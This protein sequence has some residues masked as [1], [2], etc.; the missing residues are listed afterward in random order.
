MP[1]I[2][3]LLLVGGPAA[4]DEDTPTDCTGHVI[5]GAFAGAFAGAAAGVAVDAAG[6][7]VTVE[8]GRSSSYCGSQDAPLLGA[9]Y[10]GIVAGCCLGAAGSVAGGMIAHGVCVDAPASAPGDMKH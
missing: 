5:G 4:D 2:F 9:V 1:L 3:A 10:G 7:F 8:L 6:Y